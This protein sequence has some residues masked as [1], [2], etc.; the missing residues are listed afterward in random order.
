MDSPTP[1]TRATWVSLVD[2]IVPEFPP[3]VLSEL[4]IQYLLLYPLEFDTEHIYRTEDYDDVDYEDEESEIAELLTSSQ[5]SDL[6]RVNKSTVHV[7]KFS[8]PWIYIVSKQPFYKLINSWK[9]WVHTGLYTRVALCELHTNNRIKILDSSECPFT[10]K[11]EDDVMLMTCK[12][13]EEGVK[14]LLWNKLQQS[15]LTHKIENPNI[16]FCVGVGYYPQD[17]NITL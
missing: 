1:E 8:A 7:R 11:N 9:L 2:Q 15:L 14:I 6:V 3:R 10:S 17:I 13:I 16:Y 5:V 4:I 12:K